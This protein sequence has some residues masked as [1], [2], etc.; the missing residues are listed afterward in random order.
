MQRSNAQVIA[1]SIQ[2]LYTRHLITSPDPTSN[3]IDEQEEIDPLS[4][5]STS[6]NKEDS[7]QIVEEDNMEDSNKQ[8]NSCDNND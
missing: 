8:D 1:N 3:D 4:S 7:D 2:N 6:K 5:D